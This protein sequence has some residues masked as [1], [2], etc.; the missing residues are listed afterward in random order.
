M[1][2][3]ERQNAE[4]TDQWLPAAKEGGREATA[5]ELHEE[6]YWGRESI[7]CPVVVGG[8]YL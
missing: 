1:A 6:G 3:S 5:K 4:T 8:S 7:L 2:F